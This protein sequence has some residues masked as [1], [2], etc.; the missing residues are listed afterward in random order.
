VLITSHLY[1]D[2]SQW[3]DFSAD[4]SC[5]DLLITDLDEQVHCAMYCVVRHHMLSRTCLM[6]RI[7]ACSLS[8]RVRVVFRLPRRKWLPCHAS[9]P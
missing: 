7:A 4:R 9:S 1:S 6:I 2:V 8:K 5:A 3:H